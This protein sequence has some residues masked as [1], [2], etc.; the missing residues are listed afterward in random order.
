MPED[1]W[2]SSSAFITRDLVDMFEADEK[3]LKKALNI[4][5][6]QQK[7]TSEILLT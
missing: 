6:G 1:R 4:L 7:P 2:D 3:G 5:K